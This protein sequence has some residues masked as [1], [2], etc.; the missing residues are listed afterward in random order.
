MVYKKY[1]RAVNV[2]DCVGN[3]LSAVTVAPAVSYSGVML[4]STIAALP[5]GIALESIAA[6]SGSVTMAGRVMSRQL[7]KMAKNTI[8]YGGPLRLFSVV[9]RRSPA[10][11][12]MMASG[13]TVSISWLDEVALCGPEGRDPQSNNTGS[14]TSLLV[15]KMDAR[16]AIQLRR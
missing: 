7:N 5:A 11:P 3:A 6:V 12:S 9:F 13:A 10:E 8:T 16:L 4:M 1:K 14:F 2:I 15:I